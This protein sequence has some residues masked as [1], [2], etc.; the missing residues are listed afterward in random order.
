M[1]FENAQY[2]KALLTFEDMC[3]TAEQVSDPVLMVH[4]LQKWGVELKRAERFGDAVRKSEIGNLPIGLVALMS[5]WR[6]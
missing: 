6:L 1:F 3:K 2:D 4:A 5:F